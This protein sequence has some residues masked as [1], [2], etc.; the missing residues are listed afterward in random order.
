[1]YNKSVQRVLAGSLNLRARPTEIPGDDHQKSVNIAYD[2]AGGLRSRKGGSLICTASD[3]V[4]QMLHA[5]NFRWQATKAA[6]IAGFKRYVWKMGAG[7]VDKAC[8][9]IISTAGPR[10]SNGTED[11]RWLPAAPTEKPTAATTEAVTTIVDDFQSGWVDSDGDP[12]EYNLHGVSG[13][14]IQGADDTVIAAT[15]TVT[16][17]LYDGFDKDDIFKVVLASKNW[18]KIKGC[19]FEV[20]V[21]DGTFENDYYRCKMPLKDIVAARKESVSFYIR[22]RILEVDTAAGNKNQWAE[23]ERIGSTTNTDWRS[24]VALRVKVEFT[25]ATRFWFIR[26]E[27]VG[28]EDNLL[29]GDDFQVCY[30]YDTVDGH[31]SNPSP[32]SDPIVVNHTSIKVMGMAAS[33]DGQVIG[34]N[35]YLRGG[36][37]ALP[38]RVNG[39]KLDP[40]TGL[41]TEIVPIIGSEYTI[42]ASADDLSDLSIILED[43]HDDPPDATGLADAPFYGRLLAFKDSR[44][45]WSHQNKPFAFA[46]PDGPDG[47]WD[48]IDENAGDIKRM[49]VRFQQTRLYCENA[50]MVLEGDPADALAVIHPSGIEMGTPSRFG[51]CKAVGGVDVAYLGGGIYLVDDSSV[52]KISEGIEPIFQGLQTRLWDGTVAMPIENPS[53]VAVGYEDGIIY[54]SHSNGTLVMDL[55][56]RRWFQDSRLFTCFQAEGETGILGG[57]SNGKVLHLNTG[58]TDEGA[59]IPIDFLSKAYDVGLQDSE[60]VFEDITIYHDTGGQTLDVT[61]YYAEGIGIAGTIN[62]SARSRTVIQ[63]NDGDGIRARNLAIRISGSVTVPIFIDSIDIPWYVEPREAKSYDT[64]AVNGG[65]NKVKLIRELRS[66]I[67][68]DNSVEVRLDTDI[69]AFGLALRESHTVGTNLFRRAEPIVMTGGEHYGHIF[70]VVASGTG[71]FHMADLE[72]LLQVIGLYLR[73]E[74]GEYYLSDALDFG[75]ERVKLLK[76]IEIV[77]RSVNTT[78]L[79]LSTDLPGDAIATRFTATLPATSGERSVKI[80]SPECPI[81]SGLMGIVKGR[82]YQLRLDPAVDCRIEAIR[83]WMKMIGAPN[84][85]PWG[86]YDLPQEKTQDAVWTSVPFQEDAPG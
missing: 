66:R 48:E 1:M 24:V 37:L 5:M 3:S 84:A 2:Q 33:G 28:N 35:V 73:G 10:K 85:T 9:T 11:L 83:F 69:P 51:V 7:E 13:L 81:S 58:N 64:G 16:L 4:S 29:E 70:R 26:W 72:V 6:Y 60:K 14:F 23:F 54:V 53:T 55:A 22:K 56:R 32:W 42:I 74:R 62:S 36:T 71:Y 80:P 46:N 43:D 57:Q 52:Q 20:D 63:L 31:E 79:T 65:T 76:E 27:M 30:T 45:Y 82:L 61:I 17:N 38:Y 12:L 47:D 78:L 25:L 86:W 19:T 67:E 49:V 15:K 77:Y 21:G 40:D 18:S 50:I 75:T 39:A 59:A 44:F 41:P 8:S 68:N 34:Q